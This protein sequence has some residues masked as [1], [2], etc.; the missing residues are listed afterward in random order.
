[1]YNRLN[2]FLVES[3]QI[4][5]FTD[6]EAIFYATVESYDDPEENSNNII[7]VITFVC[8]DPFKYSHEKSL[9]ATG[10]HNIKGHKSTFWK[11]HT[12]FTSRASKYILV[13]NTVGKKELRSINQLV[14]NF[15][16]VACDILEIDFLKRQIIVNGNGISNTLSIINSN[17]MELPIG[18]LEFHATE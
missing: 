11:S 14:I 10:T 18:D 8:N 13:F 17:C 6:E 16:C 7:G 9:E 15:N 2:A 4:L 5:E 12:T 3:R 1:R